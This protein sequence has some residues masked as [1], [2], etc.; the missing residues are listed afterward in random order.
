M[1]IIRKGGILVYPT[2]TLYGIGG[3][4]TRK[5]VVEKVYKIKKRD[6]GKP[7][8]VIM[9]SIA[10]IRKYCYLSR[11]QERILRKYL[12]GPYTF[13]L[14]LRKKLPVTKTKKIGVRI[15]DYG[16]IVRLCHRAGVPIIT[17]SANVSGKKNA[18]KASEVDR[19]VRKSAD[20][21]L[22]GGKTKYGKGSTV[23]DLMEY[24]ILRKGAGK[25]AFPD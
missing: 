25:F 2:D 19:S 6:R 24:K 7:L 14:R 15:P 10:M 21:L 5:N 12:P 8:S 23:V 11:T 13:V 1:E 4:A 22:D 9:A 20:L 3:D 18:R 16:P 17:T